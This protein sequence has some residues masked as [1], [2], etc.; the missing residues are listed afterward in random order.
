MTAAWL[1][2]GSAF[3]L[4]PALLALALLFSACSS[5]LTDVYHGYVEGEFVYIASPLPGIVTLAVAKGDSVKKGAPLFALESEAERSSRDEAQRRLA[6]AEAD[7]RDAA[8]GLRPS[9]LDALK[10]QQQQAIAA[11]NLAEVEYERQEKLYRS[12]T[13]AAQSLDAARTARDEQQQAVARLTA[14]LKTARLGRRTDQIAAAAANVKALEAAL[15]RAEWELAQKS[16]KAPEAAVVY[17]TLY[18]NGEW[19]GGGK[20]VVAL[21]PPASIKVRV[22]VPEARLAAI[23]AGDPVTVTV[24]GLKE[25]FAGK[26]SFISPRAEYTPPVIYSRESRAKLVYLVEAAFPPETPPNL[27]PGQP[28][29]LVFRR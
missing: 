5:P 10:A 27:H 17:D 19:A 6:Q 29:D 11:L 26:V 13:V 12:G 20:P 15:A 18:R 21:L 4:K 22:F 28:V 24:D 23:H 16:R 14:D 8:K 25:T 9:E 1:R 2:N 3:W 7:L